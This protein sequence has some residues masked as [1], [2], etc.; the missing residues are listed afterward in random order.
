MQVLTKNADM[1]TKVVKS[2][3]TIGMSFFVSLQIKM[4]SFTAVGVASVLEEADSY[5]FVIE[6]LFRFIYF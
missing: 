6:R 1:P 2:V 5:S 4:L 3:Y